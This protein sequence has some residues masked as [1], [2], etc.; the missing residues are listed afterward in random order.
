MEGER[1]R[2]RPALQLALEGFWAP[3]QILSPNEAREALLQLDAHAARV[4][5]PKARAED[6]QG[7]Q[8]FKVHLLYPWA[9]ALVRCEGLLRAAREALGSED[10]LVWFSEVN[11]KAAHSDCH[12]APHQDGIFASLAP[13]DAVVTAWLALTDAPAEMGGLFFQKGSHLLGQLSHTVD[14]QV[15]N[16][17]GFRCCEE[18][19]EEEATPVELGAGEASLHTFR[20]LHWSG[21]NLTGLRRVGLAIRY[22]RADVARSRQLQRRESAMVACGAYLPELGAFDLES[23]PSEDFGP[24][25]Q[26]QH[27]DAL[28]REQEP[29]DLQADSGE[30]ALLA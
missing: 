29:H 5:G 17:I 19:L 18:P 2:P 12:A 7:A 1:C 27:A 10:L 11:A 3:L 30:P 16:L 25:E 13:N 6:L 22:V 23:E 24:L 15:D 28:A 4:I 21:P 26:A 14:D 20:T 8:R 9:A